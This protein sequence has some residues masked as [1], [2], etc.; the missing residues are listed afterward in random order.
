MPQKRLAPQWR[1]PTWPAATRGGGG[2]G[3]HGRGSRLPAHLHGLQVRAQVDHTL[4]AERPGEHEARACAVA[5]SVRHVG[6]FCG[7]GEG[8]REGGGCAT[9]RPNTE[10]THPKRCGGEERP[11]ARLSVHQGA[12]GRLRVPTRD[13]HTWRHHRCGGRAAAG[14]P[15]TPCGGGKSS[16]GEAP[17]PG[18]SPCKPP[19]HTWP[20]TGGHALQRPPASARPPV[21]VPTAAPSPRG[22]PRAQL[23]AGGWSEDGPHPPPRATNRVHTTWSRPGDIAS[24]PVVWL[25]DGNG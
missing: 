3:K 16:L 8:G 1:A 24:E 2:T 12:C 21:H 23:Q 7:G 18:P 9:G 22:R 6:V 19:Q 17:N 25:R 20:R 4:L 10:H 11:R 15:S 14:G 13:P 5:V